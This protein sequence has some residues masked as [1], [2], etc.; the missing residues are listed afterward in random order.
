MI[1]LKNIQKSFGKNEVLKDI[2]LNIKKVKS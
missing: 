1:Q 2:N